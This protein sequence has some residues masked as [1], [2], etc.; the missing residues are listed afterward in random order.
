MADKISLTPCVRG[1]ALYC[2]LLSLVCV[3]AIGIPTRDSDVRLSCSFI[4]VSRSLLCVSP[5][6]KSRGV[7]VCEIKKHPFM[8]SRSLEL[9][10]NVRLHISVHVPYA[11]KFALTY[12]IAFSAI[13]VELCREMCVTLCSSIHHTPCSCCL[14]HKLCQENRPK[15]GV[16]W[17]QAGGLQYLGRPRRVLARQA[18]H[19]V[20]QTQLFVG[21][22]DERERAGGGRDA[23]TEPRAHGH[24]E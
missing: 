17:T 18:R 2:I 20:Q 21:K 6:C 3:R 24:A 15:V 7:V 4:R 23:Q 8:I 14:R 9:Q 22:F 11:R 16:Q 1:A 19:V 13:S 12:S 5:F 10:Y